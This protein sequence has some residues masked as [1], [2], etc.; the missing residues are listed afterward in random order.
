MLAI[1]YCRGDPVEWGECDNAETAKANASI[2]LAGLSNVEL[3]DWYMK[4]VKNGRTV[5][6]HFFTKG[7]SMN[8]EARDRAEAVRRRNELIVSLGHLPIARIMEEMAKLGTKVGN[9]CVRHA[10]L[11][12]G[13]KP[14]VDEVERSRKLSVAYARNRDERVAK[15]RKAFEQSKMKEAE[16][17]EPG[18]VLVTN[19]S[20]AR[21]QEA[22]QIFGHTGDINKAAAAIGMDPVRLR[23]QLNQMR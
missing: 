15:A 12:A 22:R 21:L 3:S 19:V 17:D 18:K 4:I 16:Q 13:I 2:M 1:L 20:M 9:S 6:R 8:I 10:L 11:N 23:R 5:G 7:P 14:V